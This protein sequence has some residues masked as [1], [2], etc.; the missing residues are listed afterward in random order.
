MKNL[1][2]KLGLFGRIILPLSIVLCAAI[3]FQTLYIKREV[4]KTLVES[5]IEMAK[6]NIDQFKILRAYY[7]ENVIKKVKARPD[8]KVGFD[9]AGK[10]DVIPLPAT[11]I[12]DLSKQFSEK[13]NGGALKLYSDFPF[14]N[15]QDRK[16]DEFATQAIA[17]LKKNPDSTFVKYVDDPEKSMVR[18]AV[19]D[20]MSES[21]VACHNS[22]PLSPF[23]NWKVGDVRG[24]LEVQ[25]PVSVQ[26]ASTDRMVLKTAGLNVGVFVFLLVLM[27]VVTLLYTVRPSKDILA[28]FRGSS[29]KTFNGA[30]NI[31]DASQVVS[32][33]SVQQA[34]AIEE[35]VASIEE[36]TAMVKNN[37][38]SAHKAESLS[39]QSTK[40]AEAGEKEIKNLVQSMQKLS[41]S[42]KKIEDIITVIDDIA[43]QTNLL[44]LNAAVEAARAGEQGKGFAVVADAVRTLAQRSASA[45][46][47]IS[48]LIRESVDSIESGTMLAQSSGDVLNKIVQS[49]RQVSDLN[50]QISVASREQSAGIQQ[51]ATV[52]NDLDKTT[53]Q[54]ASAAEQ[55]AALSKNLTDE[56]E[57]MKALLQEMSEVFEGKKSA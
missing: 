38:E 50:Q 42:S 13:N 37:T 15:R 20:R 17:E 28:R 4:G 31:S 2:Q 35:T 48:I 7:T 36:L 6:S 43:F 54:N 24:V 25:V 34:A 47:D 57:Q 22:H 44:A 27:A 51:I 53:Q 21:C 14:P 39:E 45:A 33:S 23:K 52:M 11:M 12:H 5:C 3:V 55:A 29:E 41:A 18:V 26:M 49:I 10:D 56:T 1:S 9:H 16:L 40:E 8:L 32:N 19:A 30:V 46:K